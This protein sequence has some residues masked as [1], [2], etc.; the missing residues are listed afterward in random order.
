[1]QPGSHSMLTDAARGFG[2]REKRGIWVGKALPL[3]LKTD[4]F[5]EGPVMQEA[6]TAPHP[7]NWRK[8]DTTSPASSPLGKL[9][10]SLGLGTPGISDLMTN[11]AKQE[12]V[13]QHQGLQWPPT[14]L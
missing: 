12:D 5:K 10:S 8:T 1:M 2:G 6:Y 9:R 13:G 3:L 14:R 7:R 11:V 4:L